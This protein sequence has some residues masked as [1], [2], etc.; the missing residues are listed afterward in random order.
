MSNFQLAASFSPWAVKSSSSSYE[1]IT[2]HQETRHPVCSE[3]ST[4]SYTS[5]GSFSEVKKV[6]LRS[7]LQKP[8]LELLTRLRAEPEALAWIERQSGMVARLGN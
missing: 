4:Q 1:I 2:R 5:E 8:A 3:F 6:S 7:P